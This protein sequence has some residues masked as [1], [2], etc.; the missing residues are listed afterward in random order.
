MKTYFFNLGL[1]EN[2]QLVYVA[3]DSI[4]NAIDKIKTAGSIDGELPKFTVEELV[5]IRMIGES[6]VE[7]V[8]IYQAESDATCDT[9]IFPVSDVKDIYSVINTFP[10]IN[11][12]DT[13]T[14]KARFIL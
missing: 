5:G 13:Y 14:D 7:P 9:F 4:A 11:S 2:Y 3:A 1:D 10:T 12:I 6:S 8:E